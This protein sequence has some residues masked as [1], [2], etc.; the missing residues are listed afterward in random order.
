[1]LRRVPGAIALAGALALAG[2]AKTPPAIVPVEGVATINGQPLPNASV[3]FVPMIQG[4]GAEYIATGATDEKG[5]FKV[6]CP[7]GNGACACENRVTVTNAP[8]PE[9]AR[10]M[11]AESQAELSRYDASLKN[12]PIPTDYTSA[13][14]TPL[15]VTV[16]A[17]QSD[18]K[19]ELKR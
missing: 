1:M 15:V 7:A 17:G 5:R 12:R 14:K 2:C 6:T 18:Y 19:L 8:P 13:A 4:F 9:S 10:G 16:S 11:S 3:T